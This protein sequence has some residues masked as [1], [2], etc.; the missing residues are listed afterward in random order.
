MNDKTFQINPVWK[1]ISN[2]EYNFPCG[3]VIKADRL[4]SYNG[5][6][7]RLINA[8]YGVTKVGESLSEVKE[9]HDKKCPIIRLSKRE[10]R[11]DRIPLTII[12]A[13]SCNYYY[14]KIKNKFPRG[15]PINASSIEWILE[16]TGDFENV[17]N[18]IGNLQNMGWEIPDMEGD[19]FAINRGEFSLFVYASSITLP[20]KC[21][22]KRTKLGKK[23]KWFLGKNPYFTLVEN[24]LVYRYVILN[25]EFD[26]KEDPR[27]IRC[28]IERD[29]K[30]AQSLLGIP[31]L[32]PIWRKFLDKKEYGFK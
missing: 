18:G 11:K 19:K 2:H 13:L 29:F 1:K 28:E 8:N 17:S 23:I 6:V 7:Y 24:M 31:E 3:D 20:E 26:P 14:S 5:L 12:E 10:L 25:S 22:S 16:R 30:M 4:P 15:V 9:Y 21:K 27:Y 32:P